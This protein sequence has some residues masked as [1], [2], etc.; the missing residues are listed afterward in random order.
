MKQLLNTLNECIQVL[1]SWNNRRGRLRRGD[2]FP[3]FTPNWRQRTE[4]VEGNR[5][6][7]EVRWVG[8][9]K[10]IRTQRT[11]ELLRFHASTFYY[12]RRGALRWRLVCARD[13]NE[14]VRT[15]DCRV[16]VFPRKWKTFKENLKT[17]P[18]RCC[19]TN[20]KCHNL[21]GSQRWLLG[22]TGYYLTALSWDWRSEVRSW[23]VSQGAACGGQWLTQYWSFHVQYDKLA[24]RE[25][26]WTAECGKNISTHTATAP[27]WPQT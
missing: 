27:Q 23:S 24:L 11:H 15:R 7:G 21:A 20:L 6:A 14:D 18:F 1:C 25:I 4:S 9:K 3:V 2:I 19:W 10:K 26:K 13:N 22:G 12:I 17:D 16:K 5:H 8:E